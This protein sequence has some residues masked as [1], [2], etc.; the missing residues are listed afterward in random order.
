MCMGFDP[1]RFLFVFLN[2]QTTPLICKFVC[3]E[4]QYEFGLSPV[5]FYLF[6]FFYLHPPRLEPA[7]TCEDLWQAFELSVRK[8]RTRNYIPFFKDVL[9]RMFL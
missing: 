6:F 3:N 1:L 2:K 8:L 9:L 7:L 5:F 4:M